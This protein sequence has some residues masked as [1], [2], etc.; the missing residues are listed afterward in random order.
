MKNKGDSKVVEIKTLM[1]LVNLTE[2]NDKVII[3]CS[4]DW[5]VPCY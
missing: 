3:D 5:C 2:N 1:E 4:A